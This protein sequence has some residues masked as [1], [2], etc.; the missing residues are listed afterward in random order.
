M[1]EYAAEDWGDSN[2][3]ESRT[4]EEIL[5]ENTYYEAVGLE[6]ENPAA[7]LAK[8]DSVILL[9]LPGANNYTFNSTMSIVLLTI[10]LGS[11]VV[12]PAMSAFF[13]RTLDA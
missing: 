7:A 5:I 8:Y 2:P 13:N 1:E 9:E 10:R 12:L 4:Q 11:L 6:N 3:T